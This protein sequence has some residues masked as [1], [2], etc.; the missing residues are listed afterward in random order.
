MASMVMASSSGSATSSV[1]PVSLAWSIT[2]IPPVK[3][4]PQVTTAPEKAVENP[5][6]APPASTVTSIETPTAI[7]P[8]RI[9]FHWR[10]TSG[11]GCWW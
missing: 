2:S 1:A 3:A 10:T 5:S 11:A 9:N 6:S 8:I 4:P 7:Q